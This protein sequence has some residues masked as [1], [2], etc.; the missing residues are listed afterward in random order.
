MKNLK[1]LYNF[2]I[3]LLLVFKLYLLLTK[4]ISI[5]ELNS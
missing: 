1:I 3:N 2:L 4:S 5:L